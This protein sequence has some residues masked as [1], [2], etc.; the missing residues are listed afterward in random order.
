[1]DIVPYVSEDFVLAPPLA[2]IV[3]FKVEAASFRLGLEIFAKMGSKIYIRF[4]PAGFSVMVAPSVV[5]RKGGAKEAEGS[6]RQQSTGEY[7]FRKRN[8]LRYKYRVNDLAGYE[9]PHY[10]IAVYLN[11]FISRISDVKRDYISFRVRVNFTASQDTGIEI[12]T[13][14]SAGG[15]NTPTIKPPAEIAYPGLSQY[16]HFYDGVNPHGLL[17]PT[18]LMS[19][20][21]TTKKSKVAELEFRRYKLTGNVHVCAMPAGGGPAVVSEPL[22][23]DLSN[24]EYEVDVD[25]ET[26]Y[27]IRKVI[28]K[29]NE[30]IHKMTKLSK[31]VVQVFMNIENTEA[32]LCLCTFLGTQATATFYIPHIP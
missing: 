4:T 6:A 7:V 8:L 21:S 28:M 22:D 18:V 10:D 32:P 29:Q 5:I 20:A 23:G 11:D 14:G 19:A 27:D 31:S 1:M 13:Q 16:S 26:G 24:S 17:S 12:N 3:R 9:Y 25:V 15:K 2:N 30:W